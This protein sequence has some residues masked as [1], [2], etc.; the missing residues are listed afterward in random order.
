MRQGA[1]W[2]QGWRKGGLLKELE[3]RG[4]DDTL[5]FFLAG[6]GRA[7]ILPVKKP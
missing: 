7:R 3:V 5:P 2:G 1:Q 6:I 4:S